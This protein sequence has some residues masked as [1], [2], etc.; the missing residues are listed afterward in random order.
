[1]P[2]PKADSK[3]WNEEVKFYESSTKEQRTKRSKE[4]GYDTR[5]NYQTKMAQRGVHLIADNPPITT[6]YKLPPDSTWEEHLAAIRAISK[7]TAFHVQVPNEITIKIDTDLPMALTFTADWQLGQFGVDYDAFERDVKFLEKQAGF[8]VHVGG[9]G[10]ENM[11]QASKVGSSQ[12]QAPV[13]VQ[14]GLYT[15][16]LK[17][18]IK[19]IWTIGTGNH[20]MWATMATGEDWDGELAKRLKLI[21]IKHYAK[22][23]LWIGKQEY[24]YLVMHKGRFN[25]SFNL[26]HSPK[27]YQRMYFPDARIVVTEHQHV[28]AVEQYQYNGKECLAMRPG[29]YSTYDDFAQQNGFFGAHIENPT[30]VLFPDRDKLVGF[31]SMYDA[32]IYLKEVRR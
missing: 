18:L 29:T 7:L 3:E 11:I 22:V 24:S 31:K 25:S 21:Y 17:R 16:S 19:R 20:N 15:L 1:M 26:T 30:A 27:Q 9:D 4:L 12:N 32:A 23:H 13:A 28:S 8:G 10:Y 6:D 2:L 5:A 14:R